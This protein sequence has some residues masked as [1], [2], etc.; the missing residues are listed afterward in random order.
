MIRLR[1]AGRNDRDVRD[2][3]S[4]KAAFEAAVKRRPGEFSLL[5]QKARVIWKSIGHEG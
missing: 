3:L 4:A 2:L 5:R 1:S